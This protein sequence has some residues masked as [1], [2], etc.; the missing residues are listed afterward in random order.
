MD[1]VKAV[2]V[3]RFDIALGRKQ[4]G[5]KDTE[6]RSPWTRCVDE[7]TLVPQCC[8][9]LRGPHCH[10]FYIAFPFPPIKVAINVWLF[11]CKSYPQTQLTVWQAV[12]P[13]CR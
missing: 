7:K 10:Y 13:Q 9:M 6:V 1:L 12:P 4:R 3:V 8:D 5:Y 2:V 11:L